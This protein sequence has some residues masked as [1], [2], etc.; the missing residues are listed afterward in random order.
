MLT[1]QL[2]RQ[3]IAANHTAW[4]SQIA[5]TAGGDVLQRDGVTWIYK[6]GPQAEVTVAFPSW[7]TD[8]ADQADQTLDEILAW[9]RARDPIHQI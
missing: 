1:T 4:F 6:P 3:A 7:L 5:S 8:S 9:C 2:V